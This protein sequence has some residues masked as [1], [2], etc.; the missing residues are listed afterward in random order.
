MDAANRTGPKQSE[1]RGLWAEY[2]DSGARWARDQLLQLYEPF[3]RAMAARMYAARVDDSV[4]FEDYLQYAH[5]GLIDAATR[6]DYRRGVTF[7]SYAS[8]RIRGAILNG[9]AK[10]S[11]AAAQ[12]R[13]QRERERERVAS[14][15]SAVA[16]DIGQ[17]TL[18]DLAA[19]TMGLAVGAL[20]DDYDS[21]SDVR[22]MADQ[23]PANNPYTVNEHR[24]LID[25]TR[26]LIAKLPPQEMAVIT[27]HYMDR[28]EFQT[29]ATRFALSKGRISQIHAKAL[30][31]LR[32][33]LTDRPKLD[34][35]L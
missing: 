30:L 7:S 31:R 21:H 4:S 13:A 17:A 14:L 5:V 15:Q 32:A 33:W 35:Q 12:Y 22:D 24:Q 1:E 11:E 26:A 3:A 29:L 25:A 8:A 19:I 20:L 27:G 34:S 18:D 2:H 9:L 23:N 16:P 28:L 6:Y 10:E